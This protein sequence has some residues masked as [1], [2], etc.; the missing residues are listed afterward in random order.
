[1]KKEVRVPPEAARLNASDV[2]LFV[3]IPNVFT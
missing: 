2:R 1:M 3:F